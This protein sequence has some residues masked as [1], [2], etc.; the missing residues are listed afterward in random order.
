MSFFHSA[1]LSIS[2]NKLNCNEVAELMLK[3]GIPCS[4]TNNTSIVPY[5]NTFKL[6]KGCRI[7]IDKVNPNSNMIENNIWKPIQKKFN[8]NCAHLSID[9]I[10]KGCIYDYFDK[11]SKCPG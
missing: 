2:S 11:T 3:S 7:I 9:N 4:V 1:V 8:L 10:F 5:K 6:E